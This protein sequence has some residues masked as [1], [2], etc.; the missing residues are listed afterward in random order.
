MESNKDRVHVRHSAALTEKL[1]KLGH[2]NEVPLLVTLLTAWASFL[3]RWHGHAEVAIDV[4]IVGGGA[5]DIGRLERY[6]ANSVS[7]PVQLPDELTVEHLLRQVNATVRRA[8]QRVDKLCAGYAQSLTSHYAK[9]ATSLGLTLFVRNERQHI[10][11]TLE[12]EKTGVAEDEAERMASAWEVALEGMAEQDYRRV[13]HLPILTSLDRVRVLQLFN[14]TDCPFPH[15]RLV[16]ELFEE[17]V[18]RTPEAIAVEYEGRTLTYAELNARSNQLARYLRNRG[19]S[20]DRLVVL[21]AERSLEM[22]VGLLGILKSGGAYVPLEPDIPAVRSRRILE[23]CAPRLI[24]T[25]TELKGRLAEIGHEGLALD[26]DWNLVGALDDRNL[27]RH[28]ALLSRNLAY[29]IYTSGST[30]EPK[31][32]MNEH[33][34]VVNRL[35][36][37]QE[38]YRLSVSDRVLQKTPF[39]FDVSV[40]EFFWTLMSGARLIVAR[41]GGHRDPAYLR[42]VIEETG[43]TTLHFVPSML[44]AFNI[45]LVLA[46]PCGMSSAVE[47]NCPLPCRASVWSAC[48]ESDCPT[49][50]VRPKPRST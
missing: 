23:G 5:S 13:G 37:M 6:P 50:M 47:K 33:L 19:V 17:Q 18:T 14:A 8:L 24:L 28:H 35:L 12:Y 2:S 48:P 38:Q 9:F 27:E 26:G 7:I 44:Q 45:P 43:V 46:Q 16:H 20:P 15:D 1:C 34:G 42:K 30:G 11:S 32:A 10:L 25:Q 21:F 40:W 31:G 49:S 4:S 3:A 39:S 41:P 36:W 29:V 22:V